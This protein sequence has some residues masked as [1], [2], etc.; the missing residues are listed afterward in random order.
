MSSVS[1]H[2]MPTGADTPCDKRI[3]GTRYSLSCGNDDIEVTN[4]NVRTELKHRPKA[5]AEQLSL[6]RVLDYPDLC[7]G[8]RAKKYPD[9]ARGRR[10]HGRLFER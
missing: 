1:H 2:T 7:H 10:V 5:V 4:R 9:P 8:R 6:L 3:D